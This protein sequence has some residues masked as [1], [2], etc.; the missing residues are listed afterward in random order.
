MSCSVACPI[1]DRCLAERFVRRV[2]ERKRRPVAGGRERDR[3]N[4]AGDERRLLVEA[5]RESEIE[6]LVD[7]TG[8]S[9]NGSGLLAEK[10]KSGGDENG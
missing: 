4:P 5:E 6:Q 1:W 2:V 9:D 7:E 10:L 8:V 3:R